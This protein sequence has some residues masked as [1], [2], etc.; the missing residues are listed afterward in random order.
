MRSLNE[1]ES[2]SLFTRIE[3]L[4]LLHS[5]GNATYTDTFEMDELKAIWRE[6]IKVLPGGKVE[7]V[8]AHG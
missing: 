7:E 2:K 3:E 8:K 6:S 4:E 1:A 5:V